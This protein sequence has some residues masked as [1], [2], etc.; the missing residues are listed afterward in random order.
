MV[1][2]FIDPGHGGTDP[3][4]VSQGLKE[5]EVTLA[6][7]LKLSTILNEKYNGHIVKL[8]R[9]TD[10]TLSLQERT[11]MANQWGAD[12][13]VSIHIN[14]G[15][16]TGFESFIYNGNYAGKQQTNELR[17]GIH[18]KIIQA[19]SF[20]DRGWKEANFHMLRESSMPA[21]L[22]ENG[23]ID[24]KL[25]ARKLNDNTFVTQIAEGHASG[26]AD[27]LLLQANNYIKNRYH[28]IKKGDTLWALALKYDTTVANL[29]KLNQEITPKR[30]QIGQKIKLH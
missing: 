29:Q 14:A 2:I 19:T 30:L 7:A 10:V 28:T 6:I 26:L 11:D 13:L 12:Y 18:Q 24:H 25:D 8:S 21:I 27:I 4:A 17:K 9:T 16:G 23:F 15:G 3:G 5:K 20:V 1:K 22:T